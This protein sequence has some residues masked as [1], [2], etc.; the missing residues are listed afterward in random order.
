M[1]AWNSHLVGSK[2][3][4]PQE[5]GDSV[6]KATQECYDFP[7]CMP[8][9]RRQGWTRYNPVCPTFIGCCAKPDNVIKSHNITESVEVFTVENKPQGEV[10]VTMENSK[11]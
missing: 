4:I 1:V 3:T 8:S 6:A 11:L 2:G 7:F 10:G 9:L 5:E